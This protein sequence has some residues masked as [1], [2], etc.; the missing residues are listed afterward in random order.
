MV[1]EI[2]SKEGVD[3]LPRKCFRLEMTYSVDFYVDVCK[4]RLWNLHTE[5]ICLIFWLHLLYEVQSSNI[6][7][8]YQ[9][10]EATNVCVLI[11]GAVYK[12]KTP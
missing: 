11:S 6:K 10:T 3:L 1:K 4:S 9:Y 2:A 7:T 5:H 12:N 8:K